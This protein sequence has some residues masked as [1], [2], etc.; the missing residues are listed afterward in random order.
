VSL[1]NLT[2]FVIPFFL[3]SANSMAEV[4]APGSL[5]FDFGALGRMKASGT[6]EQTTTTDLYALRPAFLPDGSF[7]VPTGL[8]GGYFRSEK[9]IL[10]AF[11]PSGMP[12]PMFAG[13]DGAPSSRVFVADP[14]YPDDVGKAA[15]GILRYSDGKMIVTVASSGG[16]GPGFVA[17][18][19]STG[20]LDTTFGDGGVV[21]RALFQPT[22]SNGGKLYFIDYPGISSLL[23]SGQVNTE[24]NG[25]QKLVIPDFSTKYLTRQQDGK[26]LLAGQII[27]PN[28]VDN[29][30]RYSAAL[31]RVD[32]SGQL[33]SS[34]GNQ[35][36]LILASNSENR[37]ASFVLASPNTLIVGGTDNSDNSSFVAVLNSQR[38]I[39]RQRTGII[40]P[41]GGYLKSMA[42]QQDGK[43]LLGGDWGVR[44]LNPD[45]TDDT[46]FTMLKPSDSSIPGALWLFSRTDRTILSGDPVSIIRQVP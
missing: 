19:H 43:L 15:T 31:V 17:R 39:V 9:A 30:N 7:I 14:G 45:L 21:R 37:E 46:S 36:I 13:A 25:G 3:V 1:K 5:D 2:H 16:K 6:A 12:N 42:R 24:F 4:P 10:T 34:F 38:V 23:P 32:P 20:E 44:R 35:G 28:P 11:Y 27:V 18:L 8:L 40:A 26:L 22:I 29:R 33:D 41:Q